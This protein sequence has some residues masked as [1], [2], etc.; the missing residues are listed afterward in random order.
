MDIKTIRKRV[1]AG[2]YLVQ[3]HAVQH[4]LKEGFERK[5]MVEAILTGK[6]IEEYVDDQRVLICGSGERYALVGLQSVFRRPTESP[7]STN[8][9]HW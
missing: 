8:S 7:T 5:H 3:I 1:Q 2:N 6:I 4:A 9:A